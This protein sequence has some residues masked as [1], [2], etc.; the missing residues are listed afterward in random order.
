MRTLIALIALSLTATLPAV[1]SGRNDPG[2]I[3]TGKCSAGASWKLKAKNEDGLIETE[4]EVDQN[5][6][7][8]RWNVVIRRDG[9]VVF[10]GARTTRP[11]SGSFELNRR[12]GTLRA[13][14]ASSRRHGPS[15]AARSAVLP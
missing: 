15:A 5:I 9:A 10:R 12:W 11:P 1:A 7:G 6:S 8:R 2:V 14:S 3:K 13:P 4:F